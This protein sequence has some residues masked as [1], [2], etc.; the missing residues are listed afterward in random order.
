[1]LDSMSTTPPTRPR[2]HRPV[3]WVG[4]V[5]LVAG[6][7]ILAFGMGVVGLAVLDDC[8]CAIPPMS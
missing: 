3:F 6:L 8:F 7:G 4:I 2:N 1:M 5:L